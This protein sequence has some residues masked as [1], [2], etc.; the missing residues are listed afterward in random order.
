MG[1]VGATAPILDGRVART[2]AGPADEIFDPVAASWRRGP[3]GMASN[4]ATGGASEFLT[5]GLGAGILNKACWNLSWRGQR[6]AEGEIDCRQV[7][8]IRWKGLNFYFYKQ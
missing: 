7:L 2:L 4:G 6:H 8:Q 5:A 3:L 1:E